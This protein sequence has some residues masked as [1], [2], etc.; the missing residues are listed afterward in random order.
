M[1]R[2]AQSPCP[3]AG[4][5]PLPFRPENR[6]LSLKH[7]DYRRYR[8]EQLPRLVAPTMKY[9]RFSIL[10]TAF[11]AAACGD[12]VTLAGPPTSAPKVYSVTVAPATATLNIGDKITLTAAVN[13]DA[14]VA[15]TVTWSSSGAAA[16]VD[17]GGVV[18][19]VSASPGIA[20][21]ATST[22]NTSVKGCGS[23]VIA[24]VAPA[25]PA[26]VSIATI[27]AGNTNAPVNP[28]A[29]AG[30]IDVK[31]NVNPGNQSISKVVL[32][33][34]SVRADSQTYTAAD[35][36]ALRAAADLAVA[37]QTTFPQVL[38]S[39]NTA[40]YSA[41]G[42][43]RWPNGLQGVSAQVYTKQ[44]GSAVAAT[45]T[46]QTSLV[47]VNANT[48]LLGATVSGATVANATGYSFRTGNIAVAVTPVIYNGLSLSTATPSTIRFGGACDAVG[49][50]SIPLTAP[51]AP[52]TAWTATF[53]KAS[54]AG[55]AADFKSYEY[56]AASCPA[57]TPE[58]FALTALDNNGN[59]LFSAAAP[60]NGAANLFR[61]DN[62]APAAPA[63]VV[64]PGGRALNWINDAVSFNTDLVAGPVADA[65]V[66]GVTYTARAGTTLAAAI[67]S[68]DAANAT[69]LPASLNNTAYCLVQYSS[70]AL[71]N[72][73]ADPG[74]CA[75]TFGVDR[76]PPTISY[77]GG[78]LAAN[79][80]QAGPTIVGE[81]IVTSVDTGVIGNS[82][83]LNPSPVVGRVGEREAAGTCVTP[84]AGVC[85]LAFLAA[86]PAPSYTTAI[87]G[88][89]TDAYFT[90]TA[91]AYDNAGNA[92]AI[93]ARTIVHD[94]T[95]PALTSVFL[96][97]AANFYDGGSIQS[98]S[99]S[100][101]D[102]L[103]MKDVNWGLQF[104]A[105]ATFDFGLTTINTFNAA[106]LVSANTPV[107]FNDLF[108]VRQLQTVTGTG[109]VTVSAVQ[110]PTNIVGTLRDQANN[111]TTVSTA[112]LAASVVTGSA[113][114][115]PGA[116]AQLMNAWSVTNGATNVSDGAGPLAAAN[117]TSVTLNADAYGPTATFNPP[118]ARVDFYAQIA[119]P[120]WA[121]IGTSTS[122][123]TT[124][125]GSPNGRRH[126]Y[127][128]LWTPGAAAAYLAN[129][130]NVV[131][132]GSKSTGDALMT[133]ANTA[134]TITYP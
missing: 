16:P 106:S 99:A 83:M 122:V 92:T 94:K 77:A 132:V 131:A 109:P 116:G 48:W 118:F 4:R 86:A 36:A 20:I 76:A 82:G 55:S 57:F 130:V 17:A 85:A 134:I 40:A 37:Q 87:A 84:T 46:P 128:V 68:A 62:V 59:Q 96:S 65:G 97:N 2:R 63:T 133:V 113:T 126:R 110:K 115:Y 112:F 45:A 54:G 117:P 10:C 127:S 21:C 71:G 34:G 50:R 33:V 74:A 90:F 51:V 93:A 103:D 22:V 98:L 32:V 102:N 41:A 52:A 121:L 91:T 108:L 73:S 53:T 119:G 64:N 43:P 30:Q 56:R 28:A 105:V 9:S 67:A 88:T 42:V 66:G 13:A 39:I 79:A 14:G 80:L 3:G 61:I 107:Y 11:V 7:P 75:Q 26:S 19:A 38:F 125:D 129:P 114:A 89:A 35:A 58:G 23:V 78:S 100:A 72:K 101:A 27:T 124:D 111:A 60:A 1:G 31:L 70:D 24:A 44:G 69:A 25:I 123:A 8:A 47:F 18:T 12:K 5:R 15:T 81:F 29:V 49:A 95:P 104:G 120:R 6:P